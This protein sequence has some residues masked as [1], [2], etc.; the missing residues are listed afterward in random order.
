MV[1]KISIPTCFTNLYYTPNASCPFGTPVSSSLQNEGP[2][3][4]HPTSI[5]RLDPKKGPWTPS[6]QLKHAITSMIPH[7][8]H[9]KWR[10][11]S[12]NLFLSLEPSLICMP[13]WRWKDSNVTIWDIFAAGLFAQFSWFPPI[14]TCKISSYFTGELLISSITPTSS[15]QNW[16]EKRCEMCLL[17]YTKAT[18]KSVKGMISL[19][20]GQMCHNLL[21]PLN[22][23]ICLKPTQLIV[24]QLESIKT[25]WEHKFYLRQVFLSKE[26]PGIQL[27]SPQA[28]KQK[29]E[30]YD[31]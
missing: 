14:L 5:K 4:Q 9:T 1:A 29:L 15:Y 23:A 18:A 28:Y 22:S 13:A 17:L 25:Q 30:K 10:Y 20:S 24:F 11:N 12:C 21:I 2:L 8:Y 7:S 26:C 3:I 27:L 19:D 6:F 16:G 31:I